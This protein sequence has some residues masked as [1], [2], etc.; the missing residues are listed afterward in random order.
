MPVGMDE[1]YPF[2]AAVTAGWAVEEIIGSRICLVKKGN[3][4]VFQCG[5]PSHIESELPV[6]GF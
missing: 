6:H 3:K 5:F 1:I 4:V 2:L